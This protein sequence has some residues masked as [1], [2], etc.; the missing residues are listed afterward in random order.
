MVGVAKVAWTR[1]GEGAY[2]CGAQF[3][4]IRWKGMESQTAIANYVLDNEFKGRL[5]N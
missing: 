5:R 2:E 3:V 4:W 1:G